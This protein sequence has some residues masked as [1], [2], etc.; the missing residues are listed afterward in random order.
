MKEV[1]C[2]LMDIAQSDEFSKIKV[3]NGNSNLAEVIL[4]NPKYLNKIKDFKDQFSSGR[5]RH[6]SLELDGKFLI[7]IVKELYR[8]NGEE[9]TTKRTLNDAIRESLVGRSDRSKRE[10]QFRYFFDTHDKN[11]E[12]THH[13]I[14]VLSALNLFCSF[15]GGAKASFI[16]FLDEYNDLYLKMDNKKMVPFYSRSLSDLCAVYTIFNCRT[17]SFYREMKT[18][19]MAAREEGLELIKQKK[20]SGVSVKTDTETLRK[21]LVLFLFDA[22]G[23]DTE[24]VIEELCKLVRNNPTQFD[25]ERHYYIIRE[26]L[27]KK[28]IPS[29]KF[30]F[31]NREMLDIFCSD[32]FTLEEKDKYIKRFEYEIFQVLY[33]SYGFTED[34]ERGMF[35]LMVDPSEE[36][37]IDHSTK[38]IL[39]KS[40]NTKTEIACASSVL[41]MLRHMAI[42]LTVKKVAEKNNMAQEKWNTRSKKELIDSINRDFLSELGLLNLSPADKEFCTDT[43]RADWCISKYIDMHY[44]ELDK[45]FSKRA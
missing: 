35:L 8:E 40:L 24:K 3:I 22:Y 37:D 32:K 7:H 5:G 18:R 4:S 1:L 6:S 26:L 25:V 29:G 27:N 23:R 12:K 34:E 28:I 42:L 30:T 11:I 44:Q 19:L 43:S 38:E 20:A 33:N 15:F 10:T 36:A 9:Y 45:K 13:W 14:D 39:N 16:T 2:R 31:Q 21:Q 17:C 41:A